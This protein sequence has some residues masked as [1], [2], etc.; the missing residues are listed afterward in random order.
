MNSENV[1]HSS[2]IETNS[3][4]KSEIAVRNSWLDHQLNPNSTLPDVTVVLLD[5][6]MERQ[7]DTLPADIPFGGNA[8]SIYT[9][10]D[11]EE[12]GS[13]IFGQDATIPA[14]LIVTDSGVLLKNAGHGK[15]LYL[16]ALKALPVGI[17][18][19]SHSKLSDDATKI[20]EWLVVSGIAHKIDDRIYGQ[21]G[22]YE[23]TY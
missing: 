6:T 22:E 14:K 15:R 16:E 7:E 17:G 19:A 9:L 18:L 5:G 21:V 12:I 10:V 2:P 8:G 23:T 11:D 3:Q 20:W 1:F 4:Q 13:I